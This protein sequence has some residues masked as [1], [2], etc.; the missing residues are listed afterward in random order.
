[1]KLNTLVSIARS[2]R[3]RAL[4]ALAGLTP[5]FYR[6]AFLVAAARCGL[7]QLLALRPST[8][9]EIR[10]AL[11]IE[12][13]S[14]GGL[15]AWLRVGGSIGE[16]RLANG[17]WRLASQLARALAVPENDDLLAMLE[18]YVDL[19][20]RLVIETP[21]RLR[22]GRRF[23]LSDQDGL[24][25]ARSSRLLE[26]LIH[27]A[28]DAVVP[29]K[30]RLR[31]L[32]VGCGSGTY[33]QYSLS[34]NPALEVV[35]LEFQPQVAAL[36]RVNLANWGRIHQVTIESGDIRQFLPQGS[37]DIVTLHNNIYYF[38]VGER[39]A[40]F[41]RIRSMLGVDGTLLVTTGCAS[42]SPAMAVLNLWGAVTEGCGPL[43]HPTE[44]TDQLKAAGFASVRAKN[45]AAPLDQFY[46]FIAR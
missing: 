42:G 39:I 18:E 29:A 8:L 21:Q 46:A 6:A 19:H 31:M 41:R 45:V 5:D 34:R 7:L 38:T 23:S 28:I 40:L 32:E 10:T 20:H 27:E 4:R 33:I 22:H 14:E 30:G 26:P 44:L 43:P 11:E 3:L 12:A 15:E 16:L 13:G 25:I 35:G 36:A 37:F 1:M 2:G 24:V 17:S 9:T